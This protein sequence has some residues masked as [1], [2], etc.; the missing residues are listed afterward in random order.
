[1]KKSGAGKI[2]LIILVVALVVA[3]AAIL[4]P[5]ALVGGV[6]AVW[7]FTKKKPDTSKRNIS[8]IVAVVGLLGSVFLTSNT[9][10]A[11]KTSV[12]SVPSVSSVSYSSSKKKK[13]KNEDASASAIESSILKEVASSSSTEASSEE[14][15]PD[16]T[17]DNMPA[18]IE[19]VQ[20]RLS[21]DGFDMTGYN[22]TYDDTI[23][24][25]VVPDETK[26]YDKTKL[27]QFADGFQNKVHSY[28]NGW[29]LENNYNY[30]RPP[31]LV[32]KTQS[33]DRIASETLSG[34]MKL[35]K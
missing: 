12:P 21:E 16:I 35:K 11:K 28:F 20:Q 10:N 13:Q 8:A 9:L 5:V 32:I 2:I 19:R 25:L 18:I 29:A 31:L 17:Q 23:L 24:Y 4:M 15:T 6:G 3:I 26:Y 1:M 34:N 14:S 30:N 22:L 7:Y 27:Q 33:G